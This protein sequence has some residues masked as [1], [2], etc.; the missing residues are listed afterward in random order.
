MTAYNLSG[1]TSYNT[2]VG[3]GSAPSHFASVDK[4]LLEA[5]T[6]QQNYY[7]NPGSGFVYAGS[8][9]SDYP[10]DGDLNTIFAGNVDMVTA[11]WKVTMLCEL[12]HRWRL[13]CW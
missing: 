5:T 1:S 8:G 3:N 9:N 4:S 10:N 13:R 12:Q 2:M 6:V 7:A 11:H